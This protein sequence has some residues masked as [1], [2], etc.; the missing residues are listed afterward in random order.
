MSLYYH[1]TVIFNSGYFMSREE[2]NFKH[3]PPA[4]ST[5]AKLRTP[6]RNPPEWTPSTL[7]QPFSN[8]SFAPPLSGYVPRPDNIMNVAGV[9]TSAPQSKGIC[10]GGKS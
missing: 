4:S 3:E 5:V 10:V 8:R 9:I 7:L 1:F 6:C 2:N